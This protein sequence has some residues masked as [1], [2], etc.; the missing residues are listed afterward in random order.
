MI[1]E[2]T[3]FETRLI[4]NIILHAFKIIEIHSTIA[5]IQSKYSNIEL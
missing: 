2:G 3:S 4:S 1:T 5:K